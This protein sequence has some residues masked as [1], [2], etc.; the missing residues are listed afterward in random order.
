MKMTLDC[1]PCFVRQTLEAARSMTTNDA[2]QER[3]MRD[4]LCWLHDIGLDESPPVLAQRIH[5]R[6]REIG[7][8]G[9]P[10]LE[11]KTRHNA[12]ALDLLP[13]L[14]SEINASKDPLLRQSAWR[15]PAT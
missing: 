11:T 4:T 12:M 13:E 15:L 14:R 9:D 5:R 1:I 8:T 10:Y 3:I 7:K 2:E 6:L